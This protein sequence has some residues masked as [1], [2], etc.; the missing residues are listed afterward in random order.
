MERA[1]YILIRYHLRVKRGTFILGYVAYDHM[2][3]VIYYNQISHRNLS[4]LVRR[5]VQ[6]LWGNPKATGMGGVWLEGVPMLINGKKLAICKQDNTAPEILTQTSPLKMRNPELGSTLAK[7]RSMML[8]DT[9]SR[10]VLP[11]VLILFTFWFCCHELCRAFGEPRIDVKVE[12]MG[13]MLLIL[14]GFFALRHIAQCADR[15][16][17]ALEAAKKLM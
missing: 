2:D 14:G 3:K 15:Q 12:F 11:I 1:P 10:K 4:Y 16:V 9:F 7:Q 5:S 6:E 13:G 8:L 17:S